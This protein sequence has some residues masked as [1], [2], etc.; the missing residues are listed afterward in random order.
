[1][2][3]RYRLLGPLD[4][5]ADDGRPVDL[6]GPKP[7]AVLAVLLLDAGRVVA[8]DRLIDALWGDAPPA[9]AQ[10]TLQ[11]Y[12][13][14]LRRALGGPTVLVTQ[15]PG[16]RLDVDPGDIDAVVFERHLLS[17]TEHLAAGRP[18]EAL[19]ELEA[20]RR[21]W[22]GPA[23]ADRAFERFA[24]A[25][26]ARLDELHLRVVE[27]WAEAALAT[28]RHGEVA[29]ELATHVAE[30]PLRSGLRASLMLALY[31]GGRQTEALRVYDEGRTVL[32]EELGAAP[33]GELQRLQERILAHDATLDAP[34]APAAPAAP[35]TAPAPARSTT[36]ARPSPGFVGRAD[37]LARVDRLLEGLARG[38]GGVVLVAG[39]AGIG[40]T[41][42]AEAVAERARARGVLVAWGR[43]F[44][45]EGTPAFWPWVEVLRHAFAGLDADGPGAVVREVGAGAGLL[46]RL[47]PELAPLL[48]AAPGGMESADD[49][50]RF[51]LN[52]AVARTVVAIAARRPLVV[53][54]DDVHWADAPTLRLLRAL[55]GSLTLHPLVLVVTYRD[56]EVGPDLTDALA[57]L[58]RAGAVERLELTGLDEA[59]VG[60][61]LRERLD[62]PPPSDVVRAIA[63]RSAGNPFFVGELARLLDDPGGP[64]VA[65]A[66]VPPGVREVIRRRIERLPAGVEPLLT[67]AAVAG[68]EFDLRVAARAAELDETDEATLDLV[69]AALEAHLL[70]EGARVGR[71]RF[72]H[73]LVRE[74]I[75]SGLSGPRRT[76]MHR[77]LAAVLATLP[78]T[79]RAEDLAALAF[80]A[81]EG[82]VAADAADALDHARAA[83]GAAM[84][85]LSFEEAATL[86]ELALAVLDRTGAGDDETR[87]H[88]LLDL[89]IARRRQGDLA[90]G[91]EALG[92]ALALAR[93]LPRED[94]PVLVAET[95][96]QFSG[97]AWWGWWSE[98]G[99][100]DEPAI[101][102]L[103]DAL[104]RLPPDP[105]S[106]RAEVLS[107]LAIELHF[108]EG[109]EARRDDVSA[110]ALAM[111]RG[112]G[113][114]ALAHALAARHVAV[115]RPGNAGERRVLADELVATA[116][117]ARSTEL[118]AF[119]HHFLLLS[120]IERGDSAAAAAQ[121][122]EGE[123][124]ARALPL[125]HLAAQVAWSRSM[126]AAVAGRF[127]DA[128]RLQDEA[129]AST[130][131]W[132]E[133][134]AL[135]TWSAQRIALRWEQ[136]RGVELAEPLRGLVEREAI[137]VNW[138]T[139]L[140][141][142]LADAGERDEAQALFDDVAADGFAD[143]PHD[144]GRLFNLAVRALSAWLLDD[145]PRA[146]LLLPLLE[147]FVGG[148]VVQPTRL[149]YAGPVA[150]H[151]GCLRVVAGDVERGAVLLRQAVSDAARLGARSY[152]ARAEAQLGR[153]AT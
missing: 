116:R 39:E 149:V 112:L 110:E 54:L 62:E 55:A 102:A 71:F 18:A 118:E 101:A 9:S 26:A 122:D 22:R 114:R 124:V 11:A 41:R 58:G 65:G 68:R 27:R 137:N 127:D 76:R 87:F 77:R 141:L 8:V 70:E 125:P 89:G 25:E 24:T 14:N 2:S 108:A 21:L 13:S 52:D 1:M 7:R 23:L 83:I 136:G 51:S 126:L 69:D 67:A 3:L 95:A 86:G 107:R 132:S 131:R 46:V 109:A 79:G 151:A 121:L 10:G 146:T 97:G 31:R 38:G 138:K 4:V 48:P 30:H 113:D 98:L 80:H 92:A 147:P 78:S 145:A 100:A 105:S 84:A 104:D 148:H 143:V 150:F 134:E 60:R 19:A 6:G 99:T 34:A 50:L 90:G 49:G 140:A 57:A 129:L 120:A 16:Y 82:A 20:A 115:W 43:S 133:A 15:A 12:V 56:D 40:K 36:V 128:E 75:V 32:R 35:G 111:A 139:G 142:V 33:D 53:V 74:A 73:A 66:D 63:D 130:S 94:A 91:R 88:L 45:S 144:L 135:R 117:R 72:P 103:E 5:V 47:V 153:L 61:L 119:G 42:L 81:L 28:G 44:E 93:A 17:G 106:T 85:A 123:R 96:L 59:D 64:A 152:V 37:E 29:A